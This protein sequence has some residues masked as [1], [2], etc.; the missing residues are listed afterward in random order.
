[1]VFNTR[2]KLLIYQWAGSFNDLSESLEPG[3]EKLQIYSY[4]IEC[5][6]RFFVVSC[7]S[8]LL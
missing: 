4:Q 7:W 2:Q 5:G 3:L 1:M 6:Q 8:Q